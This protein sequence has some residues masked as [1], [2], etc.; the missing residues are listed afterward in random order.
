[1]TWTR[2]L[3]LS[4]DQFL[5]KAAWI[6]SVPSLYQHRPRFHY[7][8]SLIMLQ[9]GLRQEKCISGTFSR[10]SS[11]SMYRDLH[12]INLVFTHL[13]SPLTL[14]VERRVLPWIGLRQDRH[15]CAYWLVT[16]TREYSSP[17]LRRRGSILSRNRLHLIRQASKISSGALQNPPSLLHALQIGACRYGMCA[18]RAVKASLGLPRPTK[19]TLMSSVG[20]D[21]LHICCSVV[22]TK[23]ASKSGTCETWRKQ[24]ILSLI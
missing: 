8:S 16:F 7:P 20:I 4:T 18:P 17:R 2:I 6:E 10:S 5:T 12:L 3:S 23:E 21:L 14:M 9:H 13:Y 19:V 24:G 11:R 22:A 1:M 15:H